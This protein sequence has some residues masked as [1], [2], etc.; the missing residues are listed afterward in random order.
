MESVGIDQNVVGV[1]GTKGMGSEDKDNSF[2]SLKHQTLADLVRSP[3]KIEQRAKEQGHAEVIPKLVETQSRWKTPAPAVKKLNPSSLPK[4]EQGERGRIFL[5]EPT[6]EKVTV[7]RNQ[8]G[9]TY[10]GDW[11]HE[12]TGRDG[13]KF[14]ASTKQLRELV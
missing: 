2:Q 8:V 1:R 3:G 13:H 14:L 9:Q 7:V 12:V 5:F 11:I 10:A 4:K 6:K